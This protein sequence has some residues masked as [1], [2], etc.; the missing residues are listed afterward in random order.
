LAADILGWLAKYRAEVFAEIE[1][2]ILEPS[3]R[4][5]TWQQERLREFGQK[6]RW[7]DT[8]LESQAG[9]F[10]GIIFANELLDAFPVR[11]L[12]WDAG[13]REWFEWGVV[14]QGEQFGWT[15]LQ[16]AVNAPEVSLLPTEL[17]A[18]LPDGFT[19]E[20]CPAAEEWWAAAG[21][22]LASGWL[23]TLDYGLA[24]E[25]FFAPQRAQ[26]TLRAYRRHR[27]NGD[28]LATPGEQDLTAHVNFSRIQR[29][30][31]NVGLST[32]CLTTQAE[33]I[34]AIAK[35]Y[36]SEMQLLGGW[37]AAQSRELQT[38]M[39]PE[40]F[41]RAFRVLVQARPVAAG[42]TDGGVGHIA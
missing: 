23:L 4:R 20:S 22:C 27:G 25:E 37:G 34:M 17:L 8:P 32:Q 39:H 19:T 36:W 10:T 29:A 15:R 16:G 12:G 41:G 13:Q 6:V 38:L 14:C 1:Y 5:R 26:G 11:R 3:A 31:E 9:Q 35:K 40:H 30:G 7:L 18:V 33:F 2:V 21:N 24:E 28:V 42:L